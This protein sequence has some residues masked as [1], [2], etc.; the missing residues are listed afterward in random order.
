E[1]DSVSGAFLIIRTELFRRLNGFDERFF[2]YGEDLDLCL[3]V[4]KS[5]EKVVYYGKAKLLHLKGQSGLHT[6]PESV[7]RHFYNSMLIFYN[8]HYKKKYGKITAL[9]V[10]SAIKLKYL[11][12]VLFHRI[13]PR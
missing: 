13:K 4:K 3:R 9:I 5:G 7:I 2:M 1:V 8:K 12:T 10:T 6:K 11:L